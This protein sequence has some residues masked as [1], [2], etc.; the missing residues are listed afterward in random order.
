M[1]VIC[2]IDIGIHNCAIAIEEFDSNK[3]FNSKDDIYMEGKIIFLD[4]IDFAPNIKNAKITNK[5]LIN[6]S[7]YFENNLNL[8]KQCEYIF[9]E[10][11][12]KARGC[13][14]NIC[15]HL[16]HH[17]QGI[18]LYLLKDTDIN[19]KLYSSKLKTKTFDTSLMTKNQRK[20]F[21]VDETMNLLLAREDYE[22]LKKISSGKKDDYADAIMM[23]Q[24]YKSK[25]NNVS[26]SQTT[27]R[28][29]LDS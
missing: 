26:A 15:I 16:E 6:V 22:N 20:K 4:K 8:L 7:S 9:I 14:N 11:Q 5:V 13:Q 2:A 23:I 21:T 25:L 27:F 10:K 12:Y 3:T 18:L 17:I 19:I 29:T 24:S 28:Y 1:T